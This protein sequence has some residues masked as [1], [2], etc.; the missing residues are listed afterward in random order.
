MTS[1]AQGA[2]HGAIG[3]ADAGSVRLFAIASILA[4][5]FGQP[6]AWLGCVRQVLQIGGHDAGHAAL[7][8]VETVYRLHS[9]LRLGVSMRVFLVVF[10][11]MYQ[12]I[13]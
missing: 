4:R 12:S 5:T 9:S 6:A 13:S 2:G 3:R 7:P 8:L 10:A 11:K 1:A